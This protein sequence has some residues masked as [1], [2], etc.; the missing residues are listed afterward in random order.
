MTTPAGEV[1]P[2]PSDSMNRIIHT[3]TMLAIRPNFNHCRTCSARLV[4]PV[5]S[6]DKQ[7]P[8][9]SRLCYEII[10]RVNDLPVGSSCS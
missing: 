8:S 5:F 3:M 1:S 4:N 9:T 7:V 2:L 6:V 10:E